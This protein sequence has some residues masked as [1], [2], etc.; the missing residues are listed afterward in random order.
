MRSIRHTT[1]ILLLGALLGFALA[2]STGVMASRGSRPADLPVQDA[3]LM[4]DVMTRVKDEYVTAVD[5]HALMDHAIR[6]MVSG[7]DPHSAFL[8]AK[9]LESL[10]VSSEGSYAGIGIEV[11]LDDGRIVVVAPLEGS[12]A[13]R[14][15][16]RTGDAIVAIDDRP[17]RATQLDEAVARVRGEPGTS[18]RLTLERAGLAT[19]VDYRIERAMIRIHSV[20]QSSLE[21]GYGYVRITQF[22]ETTPDE[23]KAGFAALRGDSETSLRGIVLD[24]R[25][26]PGG[27]LESGVE[28]ADAFLDSGLIV[29]A[30]GRSRDSRFHM[31]AKP[32]D[33]SG[34]ARIAVLVD[35]GSASAAE[36]VAGALRDHGRAVLIGRKTFGKGSVQTVLP[37]EG[38]QAL[39]LTT[40]IYYTPSGAA[41]DGKG[42]VPDVV[43][44]K[45]DCDECAATRAA[46][47]SPRDDPEVVAALAWLK[48]QAPAR[49]AGDGGPGAR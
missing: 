36:I 26:N 29:S 15:G 39:K 44:E 46:R 20:R 48:K 41:I 42:L 47:A 38:G 13:E 33:L 12:P 31:D 19:P 9:E 18:V 3:R 7:L 35:G 14:A 32:G 28:V 1:L 40:S 16:L 4:A 49:L 2:T 23:L 6:G 21:P 43:L 34:G 22:S 11:S 5:D 24:L 27:V 10:R 37:L 30:S 8:D 17:V 45:E 25:S